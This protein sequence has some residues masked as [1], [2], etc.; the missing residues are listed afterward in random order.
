[1]QQAPEYSDSSDD[2]QQNVS[3]KQKSLSKP[4][5]LRMRI[6]QLYKTEHQNAEALSNCWGI[7]Y[8]FYT[9]NKINN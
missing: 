5:K 7:I 3:N 9:I 8:Y 1:M 2:E 6:I 4:E